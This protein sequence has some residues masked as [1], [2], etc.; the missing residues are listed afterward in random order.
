MWVP[1]DGGDGGVVATQHGCLELVH[2]TPQAD[3]MD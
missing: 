1:V 3:T 2:A